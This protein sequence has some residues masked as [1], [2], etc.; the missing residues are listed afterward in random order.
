MK[1]FYMTNA[2]SEKVR[3]HSLHMYRGSFSDWSC[4]KLWQGFYL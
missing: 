4:W 1:P 3:Q 2:I